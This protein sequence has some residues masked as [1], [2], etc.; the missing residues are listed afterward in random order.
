MY[1]IDTTGPSAGDIQLTLKNGGADLNWQDGF[2]DN[3]NDGGLISVSTPLVV[4]SGGSAS[5]TLQ[6]RVQVGGQLT[7][8]ANQTS[9]RAERIAYVS[10]LKL[11]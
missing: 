5:I 2:V 8:G 1:V 7:Y 4:A 9:A 3:V 10:I 11:A 6:M